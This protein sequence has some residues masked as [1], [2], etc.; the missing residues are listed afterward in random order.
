VRSTNKSSNWRTWA[1]LYAN[2][3]GRPCVAYKCSDGLIRYQIE[4]WPMSGQL[5]GTEVPSEVKK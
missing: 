1:R 3:T 4:N 2:V 5:L